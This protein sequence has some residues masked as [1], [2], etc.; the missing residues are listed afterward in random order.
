MHSNQF[1][2][3]SA[4]KFGPSATDFTQTRRP[5]SIL[6]RCCDDGRCGGTTGG[7]SNPPRG[8][9]GTRGNVPRTGAKD[10]GGQTST[11]VAQE[12]ERRDAA[13]FGRGGGRSDGR[14]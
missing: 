5:F 1:L 6:F 12:Q 9:Q 7:Q 8:V 4:P 14:T 13:R 2:P 10:A 3:G 11:A